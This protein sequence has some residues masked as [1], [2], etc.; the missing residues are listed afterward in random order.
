MKQLL[1]QLVSS[2][3]VALGLFQAIAGT[4]NGIWLAKI[5]F[6]PSILNYE[7]AY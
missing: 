7:A 1:D 4:R 2:P 5:I 3:C 6:L